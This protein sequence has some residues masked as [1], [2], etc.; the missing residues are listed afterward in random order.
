MNMIKSLSS[1]ARWDLI[2]LVQ[3]HGSLDREYETK[4]DGWVASCL[5]DA[6]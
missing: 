3:S 5:T 1:L 2:H 4:E 6:L